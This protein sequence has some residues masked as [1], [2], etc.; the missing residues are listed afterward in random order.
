MSIG[1]EVLI[2]LDID[3]P[4]WVGQHVHG[5]PTYTEGTLMKLHSVMGT[6]KGLRKAQVNLNLKKNNKK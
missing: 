5:T 4:P 1:C 6:F 3:V 2:F